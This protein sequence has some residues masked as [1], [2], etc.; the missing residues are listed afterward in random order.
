MEPV[1]YTGSILGLDLASVPQ[2]R[3]AIE[4]AISSGKMTSSAAV[5]IPPSEDKVV[6][7]FIAAYGSAESAGPRSRRAGLLGVCAMAIR[8]DQLVE[9]SLKPLSP[10][11]IDLE[12][13]DAN[14]PSGRQLLHYH[15]S[16][17]P[18]YVSSSVVKT[19]MKWSTKI[20]PGERSWIFTAYPTTR[21]ISQHRSWQSRTILRRRAASDGPHGVHLLGQ[22]AKDP[23]GGE[24]GDRAHPGARPGDLEAR[25]SREGVGP[26]ADRPDGTGGAAA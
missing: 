14:A 23:A 26:V 9:N 8:V 7:S 15:A 11:G 2:L 19:G 3:D 6:W 21:F 17:A 22:A 4:H 5:E 20:T 1:E 12:L 18:G 25:D 24:P 13:L 16:R 10:A